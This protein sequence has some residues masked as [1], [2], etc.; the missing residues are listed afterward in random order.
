MQYRCAKFIA[1]RYLQ[2]A[3]ERNVR[4]EIMNYLIN[5]DENSILTALESW[6]WLEFSG[7]KP[8]LVTAFA[9]VFFSGESGIYFL[10]TVGGS[11]QF[12]AQSRQELE[13][14]LSTEEG[15]E[16][17]LLSNLVELANQENMFLLNGEAFDFKVHPTLGGKIEIE[18][19]EKGNFVVALH[20]RGQIHEQ[21][22]NLPEGSSISSI[23]ISVPK[24]TKPWW[25]V[26]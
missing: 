6:Q 24:E 12:V 10:D 18:N 19:I 25:K 13:E 11:L 22:R 20:I 16:Q 1:T 9:D 23:S 21:V 2:S 14:V 8:I 4:H 5:I 7:K 26:W 3:G 17:F 15:K